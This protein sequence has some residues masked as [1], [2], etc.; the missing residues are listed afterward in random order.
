[1]A[2]KITMA[3]DW[4]ALGPILHTWG[5]FSIWSRFSTEVAPDLIVTPFL[6][7]RDPYKGNV[8]YTAVPKGLVVLHGRGE[9]HLRML[10]EE[11]GPRLHLP[12]AFVLDA[13]ERLLH[14]VNDRRVMP[15]DRLSMM[16]R[17]AV[18]AFAGGDECW[19]LDAWCKGLD[20]GLEQL[21]TVAEVTE[22]LGHPEVVEQMAETAKRIEAAPLRLW[23]AMFWRGE[24]YR[25]ELIA[26][27]V[28]LVG[29]LFSTLAADRTLL[30]CV[31]DAEHA[32]GVHADERNGWIH[33]GPM[34]M[35]RRHTRVEIRFTL[36]PADRRVAFLPQSVVEGEEA[37][38]EQ[39][40]PSL[41]GGL[42]CGGDNGKTEM[43]S[44]YTH[45]TLEVS[46]P[47]AVVR[48]LAEEIRRCTGASVIEAGAGDD[49]KLPWPREPSDDWHVLWSERWVY[50]L[51]PMHRDNALPWD[52]HAG[53]GL[54]EAMFFERFRRAAVRKEGSEK[55]E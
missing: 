6:F 40:M 7:G 5:E 55:P 10:L 53:L 32:F 1:M 11:V 12:F 2:R 16:A 23:E 38:G 18:L 22:L 30:R 37:E 31:A 14:N 29:E 46:N 54:S 21:P 48:H 28:P 17:A 33:C 50:V 42:L 45:S 27:E 3:A 35:Q 13:D 52:V 20:R 4:D 25:W 49:D 8:A 36:S 34:R 9:D 47:P 44:G 51:T 39:A 15:L 19:G 41:F 24:N 43:M 26:G